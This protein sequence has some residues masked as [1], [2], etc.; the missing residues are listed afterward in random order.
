VEVIGR[1]KLPFPPVD[2]QQGIAAF[3]DWKTG[4]IDAL[5]AKKKQLIEKLKEKRLAVITQAV[6][7]GL[8]P[9]APL[10]D[11]GGHVLGNVPAHREIKR[12]KFQAATGSDGGIQIGPSGGMLT[13][14][15]YDS[16]GDFKLYGQ[17]NVL[18]GD[19]EKGTRWLPT[20][21]QTSNAVAPVALDACRRGLRSPA[22]FLV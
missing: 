12:L 19:F 15:S 8:D 7:K 1:L 13:Q 9:A 18:S 16:N 17:E 5:I 14:L 21:S 4:Q 10:S 2:E 20:T 3:L 11:S 22:I 6:T